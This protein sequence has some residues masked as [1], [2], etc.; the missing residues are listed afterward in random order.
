MN[1]TTTQKGGFDAIPQAILDK[2]TR[3][4]MP[5][6]RGIDASEQTLDIA[7]VL[8]PVYDCEALVLGSGAA[9]MRATV[10]L[11]RRVA[12]DGPQ[13]HLSA[14]RELFGLSNDVG[15]DEEEE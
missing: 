8:V 10:E 6:V 12:E 3:F 15:P 14:F 7:G 13:A 11:K 9:G 5:V 2:L 4:D 1:D